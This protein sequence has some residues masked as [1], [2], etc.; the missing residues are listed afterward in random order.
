M[1][2][3]PNRNAIEIGLA[4]IIALLVLVISPGLAVTGALAVVVLAV[5]AVKLRRDRAARARRR[6]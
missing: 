6:R 5:G 3:E 1:M 2:I 4:V